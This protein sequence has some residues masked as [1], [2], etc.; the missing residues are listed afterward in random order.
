MY[1]S[2]L[3]VDKPQTPSRTDSSNNQSLCSKTK[4]PVNSKY[5]VDKYV[6]G[7]RSDMS[8][9]IAGNPTYLSYQKVQPK[10][11]NLSIPF[12]TLKKEISGGSLPSDFLNNWYQTTYPKNPLH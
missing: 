6:V 8:C 10:I 3:Y 9:P 2:S 7:Y 11:N 5:Y 4:Y 12:K 1:R